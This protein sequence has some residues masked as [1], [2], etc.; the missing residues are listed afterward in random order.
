MIF[1]VVLTKF[2]LCGIIIVNWAKEVPLQTYVE[3]TN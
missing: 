2:D 1:Y 3:Y